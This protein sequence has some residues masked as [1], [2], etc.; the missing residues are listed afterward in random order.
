MIGFAGR[1]G[2]INQLGYQKAL[3]PAYPAG[4]ADRHILPWILKYLEC[5]KASIGAWGKCLRVCVL[6]HPLNGH[7]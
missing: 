7:T 5:K 4:E 3:H 6:L 1:M 2:K